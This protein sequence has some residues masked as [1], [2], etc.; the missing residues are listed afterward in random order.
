LNDLRDCEG[1]DIPSEKELM[2]YAVPPVETPP[3]SP[4][5][6]EATAQPAQGHRPLPRYIDASEDPLDH[7]LEV[8]EYWT[9]ESVIC[10]LQRKKLIRKEKNPFGCIPFVNAFW[11]DIPGSFYSFGM[12]RRIGGVQVHLQGLRN[13]RLDDINLNLQQIWLAKIGTEI[14]AQPMRAYPGAVFKVDDIEKSLKPLIKQPIMAEAYREEDVL[15]NDA[16]RTTGANPMTVQGGQSSGNKSTGMRSS[17][18]AQ[19]VAGASSSRIQGFADV[20]IEQVFVPTLNAFIEMSRQRMEPKMMRQIVGADLWQALEMTHQGDY[21]ADMCNVIDLQV[22]VL[23]SSNLAARAKMAASLPEE[24]EMFMQPAF[25]SGLQDAGFKVNWLEVAR[26]MEQTTGWESAE[27]LFIPLTQQDKQAKMAQNPEVLK[28]QAT[29]A[30]L[31]QMGDQ[32]SQLSAQEHGQKME[33]QQGKS[34]AEAGADVLVKSLE[35]A[36]V[37]EEQPQFSGDLGDES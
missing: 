7:K 11:D 15:I 17:A 21:L 22:S 20:V 2:S 27:D 9:N 12:P 31:K 1:W 36:Q 30:R 18:G 4:M 23:A 14:A 34:L 10:V 33:Q 32:A 19:A 13:L 6:A 28:A 3:G 26:R 16:E 24:L 8:L 29:Q 37:K 25:Q 5:E 35:R